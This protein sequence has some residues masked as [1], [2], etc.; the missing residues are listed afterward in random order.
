MTRDR[1]LLLVLAINVAMVMALV[2]VGVLAKSLGVLASGADYLGDALGTG[3]SLAALRISRHPRGNPRATS[4]AALANSSFLLL[5]T[6]WVA[7]AAARRLATG[8]PAI[9]GVPVVIVGVIAAVAMI[10][11]AFILGNVKGDLNMESVMLDTVADAAAALGVAI[12][13][14]IIVA[15]QGTYWLDSLTALVIALVVGYHAVRLMRRVLAEL[16]EK[17]VPAAASEPSGAGGLVGRD[18]HTG[19]GGD[20]V[21]EPQRREAALGEQPRTFP[22]HERMD[23]E[24]DLVDQAAGEE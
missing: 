10:G 4:Y 20:A 16:A 18:D 24:R 3:L 21:L 7:A 5:V 17:R 1:R 14:A 8:A 22:E 15:S 6:L 13:G 23:Q 12:S 2:V 9:H 11:C 19:R